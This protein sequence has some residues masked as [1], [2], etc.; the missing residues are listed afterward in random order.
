MFRSN[1]CEDMEYEKKPSPKHKY[2]TRDEMKRIMEIPLSDRRAELGRRAFIF[3][4]LTGLAYVDI[5]QLHPRHIE[6]TAEGRHFIRINRKK[7]GVE[8]VI[9]L[10]PIAEQIRD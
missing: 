6:T 2:V 5:K 8:A 9:P 1:P 7:T 4:C 3:S 10:H